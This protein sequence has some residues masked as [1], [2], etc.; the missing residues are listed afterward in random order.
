LAR[1]RSLQKQA[2]VWLNAAQAFCVAETLVASAKPR[3]WRI[4]RAAVMANHIHVVVFDCPN[5]GPAVR[6]VLKGTTQAALT[7][8]AGSPRTWWTTGGSDRYKNDQQAVENAI[9]YV[10]GQANKLAEVIDMVAVRVE[11]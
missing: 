6:R 2:S 3:G 7:K 8:L 4:P 9:N 1:A 10:A 5:D 11:G